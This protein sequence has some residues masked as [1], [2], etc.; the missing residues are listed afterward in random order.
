[1][2]TTYVLWFDARGTASR[3]ALELL[4]ERGVEPE[5][6][7]FLE[8][9]P[10]VTELEALFA[11]LGVPPHALARPSEDEYQALRLSDRTPRDELLAALAAHPRILDGPILVTPERA[12]VA[13]PPER[14]L[15]A[16]PPVGVVP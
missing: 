5:L 14:V 1:M 2:P 7:R 10:T 8:D 13:R 12:L 3:R 15:E 16:L 9:P 6:R 4:R 11:R